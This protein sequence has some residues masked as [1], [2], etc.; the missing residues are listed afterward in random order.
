MVHGSGTLVVSRSFTERVGDIDRED[1]SDAVVV[2]E[3]DTV[4]RIVAVEESDAE[5]RLTEEVTDGVVL[6]DAVPLTLDVVDWELVGVR[7]LCV[8]SA[9]R[10]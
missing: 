9:V 7:R 4:S 5:A 3:L 1:E 10:L 2:G 8:D 6:A